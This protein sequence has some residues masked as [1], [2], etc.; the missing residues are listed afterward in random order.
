MRFPED[1]IVNF[2]NNGSLFNNEN[3]EDPEDP[4]EVTQL[5]EE[6]SGNESNLAEGNIYDAISTVTV[7]DI[8]QKKTDEIDPQVEGGMESRFYI[9][10]NKF[11]LYYFVKERTWDE[12]CIAI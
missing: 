3:I 6:R 4:F 9:D 5:L 7:Y 12:K 10:W 8:F 2:V 11:Q 1:I